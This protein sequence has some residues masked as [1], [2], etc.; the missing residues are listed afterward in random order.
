[1]REGVE[2]ECAVREGASGRVELLCE[3]KRRGDG[4]RGMR[5]GG[6]RCVRVGASVTMCEGRQGQICL[7][8]F[9]D[10]NY[11]EIS[12]VRWIVRF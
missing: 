3:R 11:P 9:D 4:A 8:T 2:V 1:V 10:G 12:R 6:D 5:R 7:M